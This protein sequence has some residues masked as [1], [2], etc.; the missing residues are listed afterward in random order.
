L[1]STTASHRTITADQFPKNDG[2]P[3]PRN[4]DVDTQARVYAMIE[5]ID[6]NVAACTSGSTSGS[7][8]KTRSSSL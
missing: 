3:I 6:E 1:Y 4:M 7:S 2:N 8:P 5:N